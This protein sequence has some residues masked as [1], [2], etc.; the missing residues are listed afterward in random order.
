MHRS[1][2]VESR[3]HHWADKARIRNCPT[4]LWPPNTPRKANCGPFL[5]SN[6]FRVQL[7]SRGDARCTE[8]QKP[9]VRA[10]E[11][12]V[13]LPYRRRA[14]FVDSPCL[15]DTIPRPAAG[16]GGSS[17]VSPA[18]GRGGDEMRSR[19][20]SSESSRRAASWTARGTGLA[21]GAV[22]FFM[23][24][25]FE[26]GQHGGIAQAGGGPLAADDVAQ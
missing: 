22:F 7:A 8:L 12:N 19:I 10:V 17:G 1:L 4:R 13:H 21:R 15:T 9:S 2:M 6:T 3:K 20:W 25:L 11:L 23:E 16:G 18:G 14:W 24:R 26:N 5:E